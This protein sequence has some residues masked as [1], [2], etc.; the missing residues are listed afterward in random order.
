MN[1]NEILPN[2]NELKLFLSDLVK[3]QNYFQ[4]WFQFVRRAINEK[5]RDNDTESFEFMLNPKIH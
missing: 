2:V 5:H 4:C 1:I 3:Q